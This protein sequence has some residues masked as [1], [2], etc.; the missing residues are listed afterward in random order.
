MFLPYICVVFDRKLLGNIERNLPKQK[1][2]L[3]LGARRVGKTELLQS[4]YQKKKATTLWLNGEDADTALLLEN[5]TQAGYRKLLEGFKLLIIDEA[6]FIPDIARKAKLMIDTIKPLHI[7]LTGSSAFDIVQ[8]GNPLVGR[9][10]T[11]HLYPLAQGE[12]QQMENLLQTRQNL[13]D[14]LVFG[15]YPELSNM[16]TSD[17]KANYLR[18]LVNTYLLK[19]ILMFEQIN[20]SQKLKDLL[21]LIAHQVGN[22]VSMHELGKQ[23]GMSKNTVERYLDL[24]SKVFVIYSRSGYSN[25]LRKE[26]AKSKKWYFIDNGIRNALLGD[27][28][29]LVLRNDVGALWEQYILAERI[30]TNGYRQFEVESYF[31]RTYDQQ[32]IDLIEVQ[33]KRMTA[34]ECK[35]KEEKTRIPTAFSKAYPDIP[36]HVIN[37]NNYLNWITD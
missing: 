2:S 34:F 30:K 26:V 6:Q 16:K 10:I 22:E 8:M 29:S 35:W 14:R 19:D 1:V 21:V 17:Q 18:E 3:L 32:E 31:W 7:I 36:F 12:W 23:L 5:R 15:S 24:L 20:N 9:T 25:N 33:D 37:Q 13:E 11:Y 28:R 27:F 4:I